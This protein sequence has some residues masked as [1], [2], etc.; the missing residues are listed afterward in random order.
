[1]RSYAL[2]K[3][4]PGLADSGQLIKACEYHMALSKLAAGA[5]DE[6]YAL[7]SRL[8]GYADAKQHPVDQRAADFDCIQP[9]QS[10]HHQ[11]WDAVVGQYVTFG[12][13][14]QDNDLLNG[15]DPLNGWCLK[16]MSIGAADQPLCAGWPQLQR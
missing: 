1:M 10:V 12:H 15:R 2:L 11:Q 6:A 5:Y 16:Q 14:E 13:Y 3:A 4:I 7:L 8:R 9:C